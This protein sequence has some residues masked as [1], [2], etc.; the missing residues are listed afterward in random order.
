MEFKDLVIEY[1]DQVAIMTIN[2][3]KV[4]NALNA[5]LFRQLAL[6]FSNL[7]KDENVQVIILTGATLAVDGFPVQH[8]RERSQ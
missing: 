8:A 3:P 7:E 2:R 5:E 4:L 1:K 6:A